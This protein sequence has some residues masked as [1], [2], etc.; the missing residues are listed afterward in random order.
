M[1]K[2][3][4]I[5][6]FTL[7]VVLAAAGLA[8]KPLDQAFG[9]TKDVDLAEMVSKMKVVD[10][11]GKT[12]PLY[13]EFQDENGKKVMLRDFVNKRPVILIPIFYTCKSSCLLIGASMLQ[14]VKDFR[15]EIPGK[16]F[17]VV[18]VDIKPSETIKDAQAKKKEFVEAGKA[19]RKPGIEEGFHLL[20]GTEANVRKVTDAIGFQYV[21]DAQKDRVYHPAEIVILTPDGIIS[22]YFYGMDFVP[23]LVLASLDTARR[24]ELSKTDPS[25]MRL[26]GC[27]EYDPQSRSYHL[28]VIRSL[29]ICCTLT[30]LIIITSIVR[31]EMTNKRKKT[32]NQ[33]G[34]SESSL[35][36]KL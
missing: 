5:V 23:K 30:V 35:D 19:M 20:V 32:T 24:N 34:G 25:R 36:N 8:Q 29:Q 7:L 3:L 22:D 6:T 14:L 26:F 12:V 16:D 27:L 33:S 21:Y 28:V 13:T 2:L 11:R 31:M 18:F 17:E 10:N 1:K 9:P 4:R 15:K